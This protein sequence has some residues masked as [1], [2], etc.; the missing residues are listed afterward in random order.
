MSDKIRLRKQREKTVINNI[1]KKQEKD[2]D[3]AI[4]NVC[5][6]LKIKFPSIILEIE[7]SWFLKSIVSELQKDF[8]EL[9]FHYYFD[10]SSFFCF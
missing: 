2:L 1:S 6:Q 8:P 4:A 10:S 9:D 5:K 7:K 3:I